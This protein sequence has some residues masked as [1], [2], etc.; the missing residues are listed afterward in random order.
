M[1]PSC[2]KIAPLT[3]YCH[4]FFSRNV[5]GEAQPPT[6]LGIFAGPMVTSPEGFKMR[7]T[8]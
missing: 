8:C 2:R 7:V 1:I 6:L 5:R 4:S 3:A